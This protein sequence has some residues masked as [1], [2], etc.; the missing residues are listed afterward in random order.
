MSSS[1]HIDNRKKNILILGKGPTQRLDDIT[2]TAE[3]EYAT[4]FSEQQKEFCLRL[5][6]KG[7]NSYL[8][9]NGVEIYKFKANDSQ[10][11]AAPLS[12]GKVSKDF[13]VD[14][15]KKTG[16]HRYVYDFSVDYDGIDVADILDIHKYLIIKNNIK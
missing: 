6:Y 1:V 14:Y 8:F 13:P 2:M 10:I 12:L 5:H 4:N 9:F 15:M 16:L 7:V 3:K 11:N